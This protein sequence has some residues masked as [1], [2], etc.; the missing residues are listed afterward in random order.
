MTAWCRRYDDFPD[1]KL[2]ALVQ[3]PARSSTAPGSTSSRATA[4]TSSTW[5]L[6]TSHHRSAVYRSHST[7]RVAVESATGAYTLAPMSVFA[8]LPGS[9]L[10]LMDSTA[11]VGVS[12]LYS[13]EDHIHPTDTT[14]APLASPTFTGDPKAP[15]PSAADNDTSIATTAFVTGAITTAVA[16]IAPVLRS[17]LAGLTLSVP[18]H[19]HLRHCRGCR[20]R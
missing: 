5:I 17:Y 7:K 18:W 8:T 10:P 2:K 16:T 4:P 9:S 11:T 14:R 1:L 15:T 19:G 20:G 13:R 6:T 12:A 3:F